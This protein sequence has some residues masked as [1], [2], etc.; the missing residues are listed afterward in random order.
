MYLNVRLGEHLPLGGDDVVV[1]AVQIVPAEQ[2]TFDFARDWSAR[3]SEFSDWTVQ[4]LGE[5]SD[6]PALETNCLV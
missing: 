3:D 2:Q 1:R 5:F 4:R 6:W